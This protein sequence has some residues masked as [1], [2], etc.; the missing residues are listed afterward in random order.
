[1]NVY[2]KFKNDVVVWTDLAILP[3]GLKAPV[4]H[5]CIDDVINA[6]MKYRLFGGMKYCKEG[7][8]VCNVSKKAEQL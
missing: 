8:K 4:L 2:G 7:T 5:D 3:E 1:M 6:I